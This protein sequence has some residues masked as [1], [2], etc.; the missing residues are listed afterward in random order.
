LSTFLDTLGVVDGEGL[1]PK[2]IVPVFQFFH[3]RGFNYD[4]QSYKDG[5]ELERRT[6]CVASDIIKHCVDGV[7]HVITHEE[8]YRAEGSTAPRGSTPMY[9]IMCVIA[10]RN[11]AVQY[12]DNKRWHKLTPAAIPKGTTLSRIR[13]V[14]PVFEISDDE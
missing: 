7:Y 14:N 2:A 11:A 13:K 6:K 5:I 1:H 9:H 10:K 3:A 8:F 4:V 12:F